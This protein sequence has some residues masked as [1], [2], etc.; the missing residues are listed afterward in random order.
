MVKQLIY[1]FRPWQWVKNVFVLAP[2]VFSNQLFDAA[3]A[4]RFVAGF[5]IFSLLSSGVYCINDLTD[6]EKDRRHPLKQ[7]RPLAKGTITPRTVIIASIL[8]LLVSLSLAFLLGRLFFIISLI[9]LLCNV[10]YSFGFKRIAVVDVITLSIGFVLR[11]WAGSAIASV[12]PTGWIML[13]TFFLALFLSLCK[14]R[15]EL[16]AVDTSDTGAAPVSRHYTIP[17]L[18]SAITLSATCAVM[19]FSLFALSDHAILKFK[20]KLLAITVPFVV[21]G[22]LRY[23]YLTTA[24]NRGEDPTMTAL[25]DRPL[26]ISILLW[27]LFCVGMIYVF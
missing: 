27:F 16:R 4:V 12:E 3:M 19:C 10:L 2:L 23:L 7:H 15:Q 8:L 6:L 1:T 24:K 11:V 22:I 17:F 20:T 9:Y 18:D 21:F 25:T 26:Q 5:F 13:S 14:R